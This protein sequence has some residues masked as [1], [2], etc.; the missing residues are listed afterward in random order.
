MDS[1]LVFDSRPTSLKC[2]FHSVPIQ[3]IMK[4]DAIFFIIRHHIIPQDMTRKQ[5]KPALTSIESMTCVG[6]GEGS[7]FSMMS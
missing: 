3:I 4:M 1:G 6:A 5:T 7:T 2:K